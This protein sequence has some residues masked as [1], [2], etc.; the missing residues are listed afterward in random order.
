MSHNLQTLADLADAIAKRR[1]ESPDQ[2]YTAKLLSQGV[3]K[4]AKKF[5]EEAVEL[6][7]ASMKQDKAHV[8][9]EAADVLYHLVVLLAASECAFEQ[10]HAGTGTPQGHER[11]C[12]KSRAGKKHLMETLARAVSPFRRFDRDEWSKLRADTP[13]TLTQI[14]LDELRGLNDKID[15][16]EVETIYLPLS[17]LLNLYVAAT[18]KLF[19][20]TNSFLHSEDR[21]VP[22]VI[23]IA[24]SV[25]V[26]KSTTARMGFFVMVELCLNLYVAATQKLFRATNN[27]LHSEDRKVPYVIGIAGSVAVGKSTTARILRRLLSRWPH[28][29]KVD[30][31]T[32]DGFLLPNAILEREG[33]MARKGFPES[34]DLPSILR[35]MSDIKA[36]KPKVTA[37]LYSHLTYDVLAGETLT[38][39]QP[40]ILIVEGINVLQTGRPPRDGRGIPNVSDFF[41]F[42][43]YI[44]AEIADLSDWY[45]DR[46]FSLRDGAFKNPKSYFHRYA[47]YSDVQARE[48]ATRIWETINLV[49]LRENVLPTR[50]RADLVLRKGADHAVRSVFS[51]E[52]VEPSS[53]LSGTLLPCKSTGVRR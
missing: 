50:P 25:A 17:R 47:S 26:G 20:A 51:A 15:L 34:Y 28:H 43:I 35:F 9:A 22:Y 23:G 12:R 13:M 16:Q 42:S 21:K 11:A 33:L 8:T 10:R 1:G 46:F 38:I 24:G 30:L 37:P 52:A 4:C 31:V 19:R 2:S 45:I 5:G 7:L 36:G 18:Q 44:D 3:E 49:N 29:P 39:D 40:D 6:A 53:A 27:F 14:D 32:T 41:D 48:T